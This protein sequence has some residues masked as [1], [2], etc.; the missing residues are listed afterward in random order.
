MKKQFTVLEKYH[1]GQLN[2]SPSFCFWG[3]WFKLRAMFKNLSLLVFLFLPVLSLADGGLTSGAGSVVVGPATSTS[4]ES[5]EFYD[6]WEREQIFISKGIPYELPQVQ[7]TLEGIDLIMSRLKQGAWPNWWLEALNKAMLSILVS[8]EPS[9]GAV[10][11]TDLP[12]ALRVA[13]LGQKTRIRNVSE[14]RTFESNHF[15]EPTA[16]SYRGY[17]GYYSEK[18]WLYVDQ[19]LY[20]K[21]KPIHRSAFIAHEAIYFFLRLLIREKNSD[22]TRLVV[23]HAILGTKFEKIKID[24]NEPLLHCSISPIPGLEKVTVKDYL[25]FINYEYLETTGFL[26]QKEKTTGD[27]NLVF[28][29]FNGAPQVTRVE[30]TLKNP[31]IKPENWQ[32]HEDFYYLLSAILGGLTLEKLNASEELKNTSFTGL[33][34][35]LNHEK[36]SDPLNGGVDSSD[37]TYSPIG[38][39]NTAFISF[40]MN[41]ESAISRREF[42]DFWFKNF[43][44]VI[45]KESIIDLKN[46]EFRINVN[47]TF[48]ISGDRNSTNQFLSC[49][50]FS[51]PFDF[52]QLR[53]FPI[54]SNSI[55]K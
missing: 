37:S 29:S 26:V 47:N 4:E 25:S 2:P 50:R 15:L 13:L 1:L 51:P 39:P 21:M 6:L 23:S 28:T 27:L 41:F 24:S 55:E 7:T 5:V 35:R 33:L 10:A 44:A 8:I 45:N 43:R 22:A 53:L 48:G 54:D 11:P 32:G 46:G 9:S 17:L 38:F 31:G 19:S 30:E 34:R 16:P 36:N 52:N 49:Q 42:D 40:Q 18:M 20:Q 12:K 3:D 14:I